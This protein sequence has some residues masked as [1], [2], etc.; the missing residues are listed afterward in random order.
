MFFFHTIKQMKTLGEILRDERIAK[1]VELEE[2]AAVTHIGLTF[3]KAMEEDHFEL[4]P[5]RFYIR[6]YLKSYLKALG[7]DENAF[8]AANQDK[9]APLLQEKQQET[10]ETMQRIRYSRSRR[11]GLLIVVFLVVL[12]LLVLSLVWAFKIHFRDN[13]SGVYESTGRLPQASFYYLPAREKFNW[14]FAP[15]E[16]RLE[17][18]AD[19]WLSVRR[20][21]EEAFERI[22]RSGEKESLS[23]YSF[24]LHI[25]N[26]A[27]FHYA[28]NNSE[29]RSFPENK[30]PFKLVLTPGTEKEIE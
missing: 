19:C 9:I 17:F 2:I 7:L 28:L 30:R 6:Y 10:R 16:L 20:G 25:G 13:G 22:Y 4:I 27:G 12:L 8:F 23:G 29:L 18:T 11:R 3:L 26:P 21:S 15:L 14:D 24:T 5:G 1:K